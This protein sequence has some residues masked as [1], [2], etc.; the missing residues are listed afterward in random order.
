M[1]W[2]GVQSATRR[3]V[4]AIARAQHGLISRRQLHELGYS[5]RAIDHRTANGRLHR[6]R[7]GV[8]AVGRPELTRGGVWMAA[9]LTCG[10]G[11]VLSHESAAVLWG[12]RRSGP[13]P[14]DVTVPSGRRPRR[15]GIRVHRRGQLSARHLTR[16]Q[17]IPVTTPIVTLVDVAT[18]QSRERLERSV[19]EADVLGLT[20]PFALRAALDGELA[21]WPG[22]AILRELLDRHTFVR[23]DS[24]LEQRF[25]RIVRRAGLPTP[26]TQRR[27]NGSRVDFYWP[28]LGLVV[29]TDGLRYHRTAAEQAADR[30][31]D[32]AHL[33]SGLTPL[34]FTHEQVFKEPEHVEAVLA[35]V[36]K[37]LAA[38]SAA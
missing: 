10:P 15:E 20:A 19:N 28:E 18:R 2:T 31:R 3:S 26:Q 32:Q 36:A 6:V 9:V 16:E 25:L 34:R 5:D 17:R 33:A 24:R 37:R 13:Q 12:I 27:L 38:R 21:G 23:S 35:A 8:Y 22:A 30:R 1:V 7:P 14:I 11:A 4:W 29:E